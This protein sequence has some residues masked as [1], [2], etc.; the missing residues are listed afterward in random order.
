MKQKT[1]KIKKRVVA[2]LLVLAMAASVLTN[3]VTTTEKAKATSYKEIIKFEKKEVMAPENAKTVRFTITRE[4][5]TDTERQIF[6]DAYDIS[7]KYGEDYSISYEGKDAD[8]VENST[9]MFEAFKEKSVEVTKQSELASLAAAK[10]ADSDDEDYAKGLGALE[11][12]GAKAASLPITF[13]KGQTEAKFDV[14][15]VN[16]E[17]SEY[18]ETFLLFIAL[19]DKD[20]EDKNLTTGLVTVCIQDDEKERPKNTIFFKNGDEKLGKKETNKEVYFKRTGNLAVISK[21]VLYK[22]DKP[23]GYINFVPY[24]ERQYALLP[25]GTYSLV[26]EGSSEVGKGSVTIR[27]AKKSN[28][29]LT[30]KEKKTRKKELDNLGLDEI[31]EYDEYETKKKPR[32]AASAQGWWPGWAKDEI[33]KEDSEAK[34][35]MGGPTDERFHGGGVD[36]NGVYEFDTTR[37]CVCLRT[38]AGDSWLYASYIYGDGNVSEDLTGISSVESRVHIE[39]L[40]REAKVKMG[41]HKT[42]STG[43]ISISGNGERDLSVNIPDMTQESHYIYYQNI[44]PTGWDDGCQM[45][46]PNGYRLVKRKYLFQFVNSNEVY[47]TEP[48]G[49]SVAKTVEVTGQANRQITTI[50]NNVQVN[51]N[52]GDYPVSLKGYTLINQG[53]GESDTVDLGGSTDILFDQNFLKTGI[54]GKGTDKEH[55]YSFQTQIDDNNDGVINGSDPTYRA[56]KVRPIVEKQYVNYSID[57]SADGTIELINTDKNLGK[58]DYAVFDGTP[59][60]QGFVFRQVLVQAK[61]EHSDAYD[62]FYIDVGEDGRARLHLTGDYV[63]YKFQGIFSDERNRITVQYADGAQAHGKV[64]ADDQGVVVGGDDYVPNQYATLMAEP[65][66]GYVT[67][68]VSNGRTYYGDVLYYQMDG[69]KENDVFTVDFI[70]ESEASISKGTLKGNIYINRVNLFD[71]NNTAEEALADK[72]FTVVADKTYQVRTGNSGEFEIKDF[73]GVDKGVYTAS[74]QLDNEFG[75]VQFEYSKDGQI[76]IVVPEFTNMPFYPDDVEVSVNGAGSQ[77][78][79]ISLK[80]GGTINLTANIRKRTEDSEVDDVT[81]HFYRLDD[82][83][84]RYDDVYQATA[85][86]KNTES[87][88]KYNSYLT[89][90][91]EVSADDFQYYTAVYVEA[92]GK[93]T[94]TDSETG[95]KQKIDVKTGEVNTGYRLKPQLVDETLPIMMPLPYEAGVQEGKDVDWSKL[96]LDFLGCL[97]LSVSGMGGGY[98]IS[99]EV[100]DGVYYLIA[101]FNV[102][103][104]WCNS[105]GDNYD[106]AKNTRNNLLEAESNSKPKGN[107][108]DAGM[109]TT[110]DTTGQKKGKVVGGNKKPTIKIAPT[111]MIKFTV[112]AYFDKNGAQHLYVSAFE[113]AIGVDEKIVVNIPFSVYGVPFYVNI[114]F[115]GEQTGHWECKYDESQYENLDIVNQDLGDF[116]DDHTVM[117]KQRIF[118]ECSKMSITV[119]GGIGYNN[120]VGAY[121]AGNIDPTVLVQI[122]NDSDDIQAGGDLSAY[123]GAG[124][125]MAIFNLAINLP[126]ETQFGDPELAAQIHNLTGDNAVKS[127]KDSYVKNSDLSLV[128]S[129]GSKEDIVSKLNSTTF[130]TLREGNGVAAGANQKSMIGNTFRSADIKLIRLDDKKILALG[131]EDNG[132]DKSTY[133]YLSAVTLLST[134]NGTTWGKPQK[135]SSTDGLQYNVNAIPAGD[136]RYLV[137]WSEGNVDEVIK[138]KN[139]ATDPLTAPEVARALNRFDMKGRFYKADGTPDGE[140]FTLVEDA[141]V[142]ASSL[143]AN[144]TGG[145]INLYYQRCKFDDSK[146]VKAT[147][148]LNQE[149]TFSYVTIDSKNNE[150]TMSEEQLLA[151][152]KDGTRNYKITE[153]TPFAYKGIVGDIIVI[154]RDGKLVTTDKAGN[155]TCSIDDRQVFLRVNTQTGKKF[156]Q[157]TLIPL[158]DEKHCAQNIHLEKNGDHMYLF[159]NED[160]KIRVFKDFV[161][162]KEE[163]DKNPNLQPPVIVDTATGTVTESQNPESYVSRVVF[164]DENT[165]D[166][167]TDFSTSMDTSGDILLSWIADKSLEHK[168]YNG[169]DPL[170]S[171]VYGIMLLGKEDGTYS[172]KGSPVALTNNNKTLGHLDC[173]SISDKDFLL[174]YSMLD[175]DSGYESKTAS[176]VSEKASYTS[177]LEITDIEAPDYPMPG[178]TVD[179]NVTVKNNGLKPAKDVK[180]S[181]TG[182][183][184]TQVTDKPD[185]DA[186]EDAYLYPGQTRTYAMKMTVPAGLNKDTTVNVKATD[187]TSTGEKTF[188]V[189]YDSYFVP[190]QYPSLDSH[191]NT[192][193]FTMRLMLENKGNKADVP[194]I[195]YQDDIVGSMDKDAFDEGT[196]VTDQV[197]AAKSV[198]SVRSVLKDTLADNNSLVSLKVKVGDAYDQSIDTV[199]P[200]I[201]KT[202]IGKAPGKDDLG[203]GLAKGK[204]FTSGKFKYKVTKKATKNKNGE[205]QLIGLTKKGKKASS[206]K[207]AK[208]VKLKAKKGKY[209]A[210]KYTIKTIGKKTFKSAKAKKVTLNKYIVKIPKEA[211]SKCKKL[212][213]LVIPKKL[214]KSDKKAFTGCKKWIKVSGAS[215]K[216]NKKNVKLLKKGKYKKFKV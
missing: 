98:F 86:L 24:Q 76:K 212:K 73:N 42:A 104:Y 197:I 110:S 61:K 129:D 28:K 124:A 143:Q 179:V 97:D 20:K 164:Y 181:S 161:L 128:N 186:G 130:G 26:S 47:F 194:K 39:N 56:F 69:F 162:T 54:N 5:K 169:K 116:L 46:F 172:V 132:A 13:A 117:D 94:V 112:K 184:A 67:R 100:S 9:S 188:V 64:Y 171:E 183:T 30:K 175:G 213:A 152:S 191:P 170:R 99:E 40:D 166:S 190:V 209:K 51:I 127:G 62:R 85:T 105:V 125:D 81:F 199:L 38:D 14:T 201:R 25:A 66:S 16:D 114:A 95:E 206:V 195:T 33:D 168:D 138:A 155:S 45:Y 88:G 151:R 139:A 71:S 144:A 178:E 156:T 147:D 59:N 79:D 18:D 107:T 198:G 84:K 140:A 50:N 210:A 149:T 187:G 72:Q 17:I 108:G 214:K 154:D 196:I 146:G 75:Y 93:K 167:S 113:L 90:T 106:S 207:M 23:Y 74:I 202:G 12:I 109:N 92:K 36:D 215:K 49:Q 34:V 77:N 1:G 145:L 111:F 165:M 135:I 148:L 182:I 173:V 216:V 37:D 65:K 70:P 126:I 31:P 2:S 123:I 80:T 203:Y 101:G 193:D 160:G 22:E 44:D 153:I 133:N 136:G 176:V 15:Y 189:K 121:L 158:S 87:D 8:A 204:T 115:N 55:L 58:G 53:G 103:D 185:A 6:V 141:G 208:T 174:A 177:K 63:D 82:N 57:K 19:N 120:F 200:M 122:T 89:Y 131:L 32:D 159:Y 29:K 52:N 21:A 96:Q 27:A 7:T 163:A 35:V 134:D 3:G 43:E 91:A 205:V 4:G 150:V 102:S 118:L 211:F 78:P 48:S 10:A 119:K 41:V 11:D 192:K 157:G 180:L 83:G 60:K 137:S 68:W 142:S